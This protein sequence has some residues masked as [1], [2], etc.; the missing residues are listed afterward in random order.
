MSRLGSKRFSLNSAVT[1]ALF[2]F[3]FAITLSAQI[4]TATIGG[5]VTDPTGASI[6]GAM[7]IVQN[8]ATGI[9]HQ[10]E[11]NSSGVFSV[12]QLQPGAYTVTVSKDGFET[13]KNSD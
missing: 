11:T 8:P 12:P 5:T 6:A 7:V 2:S 13:V 10:V 3:L 4:N 9:R 1:T